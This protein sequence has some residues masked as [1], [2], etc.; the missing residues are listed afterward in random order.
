[1][2]R[3]ATIKGAHQWIYYR[4]AWQMQQTMKLA[5][6]Q[7]FLATNV[8]PKFSDA[9]SGDPEVVLVRVVEQNHIDEPTV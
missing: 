2:K 1:M 3:H 7:S 5:M 4:R 8:F 9:T 6:R